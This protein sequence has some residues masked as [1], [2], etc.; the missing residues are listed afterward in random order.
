MKFTENHNNSKAAKELDR[1]DTLRGLQ[2]EFI[3]PEG[4]NVLYFCGHS[5]GLI[6]KKTKE[7]VKQELEN[8]EKMAV[9]G[10]FSANPP[11]YSYHEVLT[12]Q[13]ARLLGATSKEVVVMNGLTVNLHLAMVTFY[14]PT[15]KRFKI[16]IENN[17]FPSDHYA[18]FSQ[19][20]I[21]GFDP[22]EAVVELVS[23]PG[24]MTVD[25]QTILQTIEE[26]GDSLALVM[27]G[28]CNYLSGQ[29]FDMQT[30]TNKAHSVG[31]L[32]GFDLA[33]G[34]GNLLMKLHDWQVDFAVWCSYKY[35]NA[36]PGGAGGFYV[37]EKHLGK[38][39]IPRL[40]G[41]WGHDKKNRFKMSPVFEP[42]PTAEAWQLS[43][44]P[45]FQLAALRA[46]MEI[47][48]RAKIENLHKKSVVLTNYLEFLLR[49]NCADFAKIITPKDR[50]AMLCL[51][52]AGNTK[53][54]DSFLEKGI[55]C[56]FRSPDILRITPAPLYT[57][58][59]DVYR[60]VEVIAS[61][62]SRN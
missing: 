25:P 46:S 29:A 8:W 33:H 31:A 59:T 44:P 55:Y 37:H 24:E 27:L 7:Y 13:T 30:I 62:T 4:D 61:E 56:D 18:V 38:K 2:D 14:R 11:W 10:H 28:N 40:E 45:I 49:E 43:N 15:K 53:I 54:V 5:L 26:L 47:F 48:D 23:K 6:P 22:K 57:S 52:I 32:A 42:I 20:R 41:W 50:G 34:A 1:Q 12:D 51:R 9:E 19:A 21:H 35:L 60:L 16:L 17:T 39:D 3:Y 58:F 36:G